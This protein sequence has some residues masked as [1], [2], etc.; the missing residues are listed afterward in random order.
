LTYTFHRLGWSRAPFNDLS[1][2][3]NPKF[4]DFFRRYCT[5]FRE[6]FSDVYAGQRSAFG[7]HCHSPTPAAADGDQAKQI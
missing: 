1:N 4:C 3:K 2:K 6:V 7:A 5:A